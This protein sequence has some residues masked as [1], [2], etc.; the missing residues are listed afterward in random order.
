VAHVDA[1]VDRPD[2]SSR[3]STIFTVD[4]VGRLPARWRQTGEAA[5]RQQLLGGRPADR[6]GAGRTGTLR[7]TGD[8]EL[9]DRRATL[10]S[11]SSFS[12]LSCGSGTPGVA[13][14]GPS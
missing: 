8:Q 5:E 7:V 3:A 9:S 6:A 12:M 2:G 14:A 11:W 10:A 1:F 4:E 13:T